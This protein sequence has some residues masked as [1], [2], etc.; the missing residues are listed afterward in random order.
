MNDD[1]R[2]KLDYLFECIYL[3][4]P[5][6][7]AYELGKLTV[8]IEQLLREGSLPSKNMDNVWREK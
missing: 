1:I 8:M 6:E 2:K 7:A 4:R 5:V 3:N